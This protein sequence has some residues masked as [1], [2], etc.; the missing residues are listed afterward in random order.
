MTYQ[1]LSP[2]W[3]MAKPRPENRSLG[4]SHSGVNDDRPVARSLGR[5]QSNR[6]GSGLSRMAAD[7]AYT[8]PG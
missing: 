6:A 5:F 2:K 8:R 7:T 4:S 1:A 3:S